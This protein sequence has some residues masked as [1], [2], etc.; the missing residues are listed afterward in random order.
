MMGAGARMPAPGR[1]IGAVVASVLLSWAQADAQE[2]S[3][4][5][6]SS[7]SDSRSRTSEGTRA[8]FANVR[9]TLDVNWNRFISPVLGYRLSLRAERLDGSSLLAGGGTQTNT[10]TSSLVLQ[11]GLDLTLATPGLSINGGYRL[12]ELTQDESS[13]STLRLSERNGFLRLFYSPE[14]LPS[15]SLQLER[16][17]SVD[18]R[19]PLARDEA[20]TRFQ[21]GSQWTLRDLAL[22][23][24]FGRLVHEDNQQQRTETQDTHVGTAGY[25]GRFFDDRL[26]VQTDLSLNYSR[27]VDEFFSPGTAQFDRALQAALQAGPSLTPL[28]GPMVS[29]GPPFPLTPFSAVGFRLPAPEEVTDI[30]IGLAVSPA[31]ELPACDL[32]TFLAFRVFFT[33]DDPSSIL[34]AWTEVSSVSPVWDSIQSRFTLTIPS[35]AAR[36]FKA[37]VSVNSYPGPITATAISAPTTVAVT[38]GSQRSRSS[39]SGTLSAGLS[40]SPI[41]PV[42]VAYNMNVNVSHQDPEAI[43]TTSGTH[44]LSLVVRP[45]AK[46]TT[47]AIAQYSFNGSNQPGAVETSLTSY[48]LTAGWTPLTTLSTTLG[49]GRTESRTDGQVDNRNDTA[50]LSAAAKVFP[51]LTLDSAYSLSKVENFVN[52]QETIGQDLTFRVAA[53][54]APWISMVGNYGVQVRDT[55]PAPAGSTALSITHT[56]GGGTVYSVSRLVNFTTRFDYVSSSDGSSLASTYKVDWVPTSKISFFV[57]YSTTQSHFGDAKASTDTVTANG[58]WQI[59]R[60]LDLSANYSFSHSTTQSTLQDVQLF[61]VAASARF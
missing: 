54:M 53:Q 32:R 56:V 30:V 42:T 36:S 44:T 31:C 28:L 12:R 27:T 59:N 52:Q 13:Q 4:L 57:S 2:L 43:D 16:S 6:T 10:E 45:H 21:A 25:A 49:V 48:T 29:F 35:T 58:R 46:V 61:S 37:W 33:N 3:G 23:Y 60:A 20:D 8:D 34:A 14:Q 39:R 7:Y 50:S 17:T 19:R 38:A 55:T 15:V 41:K 18:N 1:V 11:P 22:G 51:A 47:T 40:Y 26:T 5:L 9:E 24:T